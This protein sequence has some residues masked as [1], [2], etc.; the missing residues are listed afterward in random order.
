MMTVYS[1][2]KEGLKNE[3]SDKMWCTTKILSDSIE[4]F[5]PEKQKEVLLNKIYYSMNGG[6]FDKESAER[7][8]SKMY[9][10][11]GSKI[12]HQAP[13]WTESEVRPLYE[14]VRSKIPNYN[15]YDFEVTMNMVKSDNYMKLKHWFPDESEPELINRYIEEAVNY[16]DDEDNP[17][18]TEKIWKY[19]NS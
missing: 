16:L 3:G 18:G 10:F 1:I 19:L 9:Y 2:L 11:D 17:F 15:F 5:V 12:Q 7:A 4:E 6:H 13:Y 8:I 14:R